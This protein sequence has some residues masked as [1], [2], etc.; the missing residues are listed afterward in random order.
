MI[1][2]F[3]EFDNSNNIE[4]D[5]YKILQEVNDDPSKID[6]NYNEIAEFLIDTTANI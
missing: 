6:Q 3:F 5:F 2:K 1:D 4:W